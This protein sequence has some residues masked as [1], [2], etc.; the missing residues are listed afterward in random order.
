MGLEPALQGPRFATLPERRRH[1]VELAQQLE[2]AFAQHD[3]AEW[4]RRFDAA[5]QT[6]GVI[7][8]TADVVNDRQ[9]RHIG[10]LVP[11][12]GIPG[13]GLTVASPLQL[14]GETPVPARAAPAVGQHSDAILREAGYAEAEIAAL[15]A[16]GV[17]A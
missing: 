9:M 15:R 17:V 16:R 4:Q 11:G 5:G 6:V 3:S 14:G 13:T 8:R 1:A 2:R 12:E 10:A 7:A